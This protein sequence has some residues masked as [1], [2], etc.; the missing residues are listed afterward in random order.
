MTA[1]FAVTFHK[2]QGA[3]IQK[4]VLEL[5]K[6]PKKLGALSFGSLY[7]AM[8]RVKQFDGLRRTGFKRQPRLPCQ[9]ED[10]ITFLYMR[11]KSGPVFA[12]LYP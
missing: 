1:A 6:R 12:V 10:L 7:V 11:R 8:T 2:V 5:N 4:A 3:T 9:T